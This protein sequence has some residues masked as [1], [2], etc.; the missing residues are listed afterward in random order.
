MVPQVEAQSIPLTFLT[1]DGALV[2]SLSFLQSIRQCL[3]IA[4]SAY[5]PDADWADIFHDSGSAVLS[6]NSHANGLSCAR[7]GERY[8]CD[9]DC[10]SSGLGLPCR[11]KR[12]KT[13]GGAL[14]MFFCCAVDECSGAIQPAHE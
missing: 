3:F 12:W 2:G 8:C 5:S 10:Y 14:P 7:T 13:G 4:Q 11:S 1:V 9:A 6:G